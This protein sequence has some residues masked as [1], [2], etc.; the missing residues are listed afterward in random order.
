MH[1]YCYLYSDP[2]QNRWDT[3]C[4]PTWH[5]WGCGDRSTCLTP[6]L[7]DLGYH[8]GGTL[9]CSNA[10]HRTRGFISHETTS[11]ASSRST[12]TKTNKR[13]YSYSFHHPTNW[14]LPCTPFKHLLPSV[15]FLISLVLEIRTQKSQYFD[16][17]HRI[18]R[19]DRI[20]LYYYVWYRW[21]CRRYIVRK[22]V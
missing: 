22:P 17:A 11:L 21:F 2:P 15:S 8:L 14:W 20:I 18:K 13:L 9:G 16:R 12:Q 3:L 1:A 4:D 5:G 10:L 7:S 19:R 6:F